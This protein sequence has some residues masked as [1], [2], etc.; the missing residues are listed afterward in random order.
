MKSHNVAHLL[1][2]TAN[3]RPWNREE[4]EEIRKKDEQG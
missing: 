1:I 3:P 4:E 2:Y